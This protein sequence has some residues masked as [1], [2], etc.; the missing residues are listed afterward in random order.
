[1]LFCVLT[2]VPNNA[3]AS[4]FSLFTQTAEADTT[5]VAEDS[6]FGASHKT[7]LTPSA[8][9]PQV[10]SGNKE[11]IIDLDT[12]EDD[13]AL[14]PSMGPAGTASDI[15]EI[16]EA[17]QI[18]VYTVHSGDTVKKI[19]DM[20]DVSVDTILAANDIPTGKPL[21][22]GT[23]IYILPI[24]GQVYTV[25]KGDTLKSIAK[26]FTKNGTIIT[27]SDIAFNNDIFSNED[28]EIGSTII[29]P[30]PEFSIS[31]PAKKATPVKKTTSVSPKAPAGFSVKGLIVSPVYGGIL[32]QR[33]HFGGRSVDIG[34]PTG[35]PTIAAAD[36]TVLITV[37]R[38]MNGYGKYIV[39]QHNSN[40]KSY[41]T[42][43]AHLSQI[44]VVPGQKVSQSEVIG[45]VGST[46]RSTGPHVH[47]EVRGAPNPFGYSPYVVRQRVY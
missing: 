12:N 20:F 44:D 38:T 15:S 42:L 14:L 10:L 2:L 1:M 24:D 11:K 46:G 19:A 39:I 22:A 36:G 37:N 31:T 5:P 4:V 6:I 26:K 7:A 13:M 43:Y 41:Q 16:S 47:F 40:G 34:A 18:S 45:K 29:I 27:A 30:D 17:D 8:V 32:T 33:I 23:L 28:L 25:K 9:G 21:V 35:T 3:S